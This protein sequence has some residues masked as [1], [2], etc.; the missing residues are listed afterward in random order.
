MMRA[1]CRRCVVSVTAERRRYLM[2]DGGE[3]EGYQY[4]RI[5]MI[6]ITT[7]IIQMI[8]ARPTSNSGMLQLSSAHEENLAASSSGIN[9]LEIVE[10]GIPVCQR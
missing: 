9:S 2:T 7:T 4:L 10:N 5:P 6:R 8:A 1:I 3:D